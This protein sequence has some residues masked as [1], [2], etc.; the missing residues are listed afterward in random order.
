MKKQELQV[1]SE[2]EL[3][4][5]KFKIYGTYE[6]PLF[7]AKDVAEWIGHS[8]VSKM[9]DAVD[10]EEKLMGTLFLSGQK[11]DL[12][13][14]KENGVY[15]VIMQSRKP[16]AKTVKKQFKAILHSVR[17]HGGYL[18][19]QENMTPEQIM[20]Q[21]LLAAQ[22][23]IDEKNQLIAELEPK[24]AYYDK[25]L[26]CKGLI[27]TTVIAKDYGMSAAAFNKLL[28]KHKIQ[29][30][31]G[32]QWF[33]YADYQGHGY[34]GSE[35][36]NVKSEYDEFAVIDTK[37]T[38]KGRAFLYRFLKKQGI[39]PTMERLDLFSGAEPSQQAVA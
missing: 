26:K 12:W 29:F 4:G 10:D 34:T 7:L 35:T 17:V 24:G 6:E 27:N 38:Q 36:T 30:K 20:A 31:Q 19:G 2:Q 9:L 15:E 39:V 28:H 18:A 25:I 21:G 22:S 37:W 3:L 33:L 16:I 1:L 11:R 13:M 14:L 5:K 23:I 32:R 8:Q